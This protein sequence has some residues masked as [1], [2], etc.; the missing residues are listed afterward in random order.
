MPRKSLAKERRA[1][2]LDAFERCIVKYGLEGTSL[3]QIAEEAGMTRSIIRHYIGNRDDIVNALIERV[4]VQQVAHLEAE[5]AGLSPEASIEKTLDT[6]FAPK[7]NLNT[8]EKIILDVLLTAKD[9]YPRAKTLLREMYTGV[10]E[11]FAD[12]LNNAYPQQSRD[13]CRRI[14]Y[15]LICMTEMNESFMWLGLNQT[16]HEDA[17]RTA[18]NLIQ[19]LSGE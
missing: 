4:I 6:M 17:R 15:A 11:S 8:H 13:T 14:A 1:E 16:Y 3:E 10:I 2:L 18:E 19:S 9:R 7:T 5:Y 12:D